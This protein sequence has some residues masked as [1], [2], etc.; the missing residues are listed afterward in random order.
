MVRFVACVTGWIIQTCRMANV[1]RP[2]WRLSVRIPPDAQLWDVEGIPVAIIPVQGGSML[3]QAFD[4]PVPRSFSRFSV[5]SR[6]KPIS[7]DR[8][9]LLVNRCR[10]VRPP[11]HPS[12]G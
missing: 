2:Q 6:G 3:V 5:A 7:K 4:S 11:S 10:A 8:W 1:I 9:D 12:M